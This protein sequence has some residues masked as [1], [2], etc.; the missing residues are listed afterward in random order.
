MLLRRGAAD[1]QVACSLAAIA[2]ALNAIGFFKV[3][4]YASHM[5]G[6]I[7]TLADHL[8][9]GD[10]VPAVTY[11]G[12]IGAFIAGAAVSTLLA[13]EGQRRGVPGVHSLSLLAEAVL[14][15]LLAGA[16][17]WLPEVHQTA[18]F[19]FGM[20]FLMGLQNAIVTRV[21]DARIRTTH[22]TG[23]VTDIGIEVGSL[24][25]VARRR[26][27]RAETRVNL[28]RLALHGPM[29]AAF[30]SG[31]ILGVLAYR[32]AGPLALAAAALGLAAL[33]LPGIVAARAAS[34][35]VGEPR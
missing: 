15:G 16:D 33:A 13:N 27:G 8:A 28:E 11:L 25:D 1:R 23:M 6:N 14:L 21:S 17:A 4:L 24:I 18:L 12:V 20:S 22:V 31:S 2:G 7:S 10:L 9:L 29:V 35:E 30:F 26:R 19:I 3:G 34:P 32:L 5:T